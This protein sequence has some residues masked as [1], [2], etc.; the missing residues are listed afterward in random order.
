MNIGEKIKKLWQKT[1]SEA[2]VIQGEETKDKIYYTRR[3]FKDHK[4]ARLEFLKAKERLFNVNS[5]NNVPA[6]LRTGFV[7]YNQYGTKLNSVRVKK[8]NYIKIDLP[9]PTPTYWVVVEE[10]FEDEDT[11]EFVVRPSEDPTAPKNETIKHFFKR[12]AT[13][14][15]RVSL[16]DNILTGYEIGRDEGINN[17]GEE[18][19]DLDLVNTLVSEGGW[20]FFQKYQWENLTDYLVGKK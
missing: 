7:L 13:S 20:A 5:W 17:E 16:R 1:K 4:R 19:G 2:K 11:A 10:V 12:I 8:G 6:L 18:A 9:G 3:E 14:T 15:F